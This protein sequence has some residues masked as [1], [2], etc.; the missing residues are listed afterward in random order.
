MNLPP[1]VLI[2]LLACSL[3]CGVCMV[4]LMVYLWCTY[5][6]CYDVD[7]VGGEVD[8]GGDSDQTAAALSMR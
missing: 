5:G 3:V 6:A 8:C 1:D 7:S 2:A 4:V